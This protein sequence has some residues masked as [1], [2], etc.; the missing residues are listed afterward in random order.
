MNIVQMLGIFNKIDNKKEGERSDLTE[1]EAFIKT[2]L[3][4]GKNFLSS[5]LTQHFFFFFY[6]YFLFL[7]STHSLFVPF[8]FLPVFWLTILVFLS[9]T[10]DV[11]FDSNTLC[12]NLL[13]FSLIRD[14][15]QQQRHIFTDCCTVSIAYQFALLLIYVF[16][17][18]SL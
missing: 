4:N 3:W 8:F 9:H 17:H 2:D 6:F 7:H 11:N 13:F 14:A 5:S 10:Y 16:G 12:T 15:L 18:L 1:S